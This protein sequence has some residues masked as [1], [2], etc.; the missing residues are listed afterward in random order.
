MALNL[1]LNIKFNPE[2]KM[3]TECLGEETQCFDPAWRLQ[4]CLTSEPEGFSQSLE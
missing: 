2:Y 4:A 3:N 1:T